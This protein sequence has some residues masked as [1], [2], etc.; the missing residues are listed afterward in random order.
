MSNKHMGSTALSTILAILAAGLL[1]EAGP[2]PD[3]ELAPQK[4]PLS[5][6][7]T[8][9][10]EQQN[11]RGIPGPMGGTKEGGPR[12]R[13]HIPHPIDLS[14]IRGPILTPGVGDPPF[15]AFYDL[16]ISG[17]LTPVKD[18]GQYGTCWS[19]AC[20]GALE[21]SLL[22]AGIGCFDL[23]E[24]YP[25][26]FA[27]KPF[28]TS[29]MTAFTPG[30]VAAG[31]DAIFDQGGNDLM[32][33]AL[34]ARGNGAV[35]EKACPYH[36]GS[37]RP[38]PRPQGDLPNGQENTRAPLGEAMYLFGMDSSNSAQ[39]VKYAITHYGP[40]VISMDWEDANFDDAQN[41]YRD[42]TATEM[43]L[44]HEVCIVG[45]ND[46]FGTCRFPAANR[47]TAPGAWIIRNSWGR[48][49]GHDGY[50]YLSYDS[51]LFDGT[52]FTG[53]K[54]TSH[55]IYQY[56][57]LGWCGGRGYGTSS[58]SCA[59]VFRAHKDQRITA[60]GFYA[61]A[62][63]TSYEIDVRTG[64][65]GDPGTGISPVTLSLVPAQTGTMQMPGYHIVA[66]DNPMIVSKGADF[67]VVMKLTT[68]GY[69]Y[70]IPVQEPDP[71]YSESSTSH[72]ARGYISS[73]GS[74]WQDLAP[75]CQGASLCVKAFAEK[76]D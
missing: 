50:F 75:T 70:P 4:A 66:L 55:E 63:N 59:N 28:N 29:L 25:A 3:Q 52:I 31:E 37:Y 8:R 71:G 12:V 57:P 51:P 20:I 9:W 69:V 22:K 19:F 10:V 56:D 1:L 30:A 74:T 6:A 27:Y 24:W 13:G 39:D 34:L 14:H 15:P 58:A 45:W 23:S 43:D 35:A 2:A 7:F 33:T 44:N 17:W 26:Y 62:A 76:V 32:S 53:A 65:T 46:N 54:R 61:T 5:P 68:P 16:R 64:L 18:Q 67:A 60:V 36:P 72:H 11:P 41:T 40:V 48:A 47:P 42:T 73:N 38:E 21:S 49:W